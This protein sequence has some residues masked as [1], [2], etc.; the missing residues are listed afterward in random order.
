MAPTLPYT[1]KR[2]VISAAANGDNALVA[3]VS[4][5]QIRVLALEVS[6]SGAVNGKLQ[7][8]STDITGLHYF[9][10]AGDVWCLPY[11]VAGWCET[12]VSKK[13]DLNLSGAVAVGGVLVYAEV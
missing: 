7:S 9:A 4:G 5:K 11:N 1:I 2:A 12:V 8:D 6:A 3:A 13:L 10:A